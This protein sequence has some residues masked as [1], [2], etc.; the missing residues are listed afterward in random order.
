MKEK[1]ELEQLVLKRAAEIKKSMEL[2][3][4]DCKNDNF[5]K[6]DFKI[7]YLIHLIARL[8]KISRKEAHCFSVR[9]I[10]KHL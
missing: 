7:T 5:N 10:P 2:V 6:T 9:G 8:T 1:T 3:M 4:E